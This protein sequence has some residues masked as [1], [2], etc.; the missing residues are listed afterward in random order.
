M[1]IVFFGSDDFANSILNTLLEGGYSPILVLTAPDKPRG[2]GK[3]T[4]PTEVKRNSLNNNIRVITPYKISKSIVDEIRELSP[5]I[6]I[7][8]SYGLF[9]PMSLLK[10]V[11]YPL[12]I[13]PSL[14]PRYRGAS[15][16]RSAL[17]NG[18]KK[19]GVTIMK[20]IKQMDAG[21]IYMQRSIDIG[22]DDYIS[23]KQRLIQLSQTMILKT[24]SSIKNGIP[25][26][27][28]PQGGEP[29]FCYK[30]NKEDL[31]IN[32]NVDQSK[33]YNRM[34]AF[35]DVGL[36]TFLNG[37]R[38][39]IFSFDRSDKVLRPGYI[40]ISSKKLFVGTA[41][42]ALEILKLQFPGKKPIMAKDAI[43]GGKFNNA[44]KFSDG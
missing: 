44:E 9:L 31:K 30:F 10:L 1:N 35:S 34:R 28:R 3:K 4:L 19:T 11:E 38:I 7:T 2:R 26:S 43:N 27:L 24:L 8:I 5:S 17:L 12:N 23:L 42:K 36:F 33:L 22:D 18:D 16:I 14:L 32:W 25:L 6:F 13:H 41:N 37:Q 20:M 21:D 15:P 29:T 39:K 40:E